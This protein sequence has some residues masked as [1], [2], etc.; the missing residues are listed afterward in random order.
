MKSTL[1][2]Y[3]NRIQDAN[4]NLLTLNKMALK[5]CTCNIRFG[6]DEDDACEAC[7]AVGVLENYL[8]ELGC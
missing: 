3:K 4:K 8:D 6:L 2:N 7:C 5:E 1:C